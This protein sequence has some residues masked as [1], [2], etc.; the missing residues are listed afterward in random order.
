MLIN[1]SKIMIFLHPSQM[2]EIGKEEAIVT[3][4][5]NPT[6]V[7][8]HVEKR[9][10]EENMKKA[11]AI[12]LACIRV[13]KSKRRAR[14]KKFYLKLKAL[15]GEHILAMKILS[16]IT[17]MITSLEKLMVMSTWRSIRRMLQIPLVIWVT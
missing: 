8:K 7:R 12:T 10:E 16:K 9:E 3:H 15:M 17:K 1:N 5:L 13:S 4:I 11:V 2:K 6:I 14:R